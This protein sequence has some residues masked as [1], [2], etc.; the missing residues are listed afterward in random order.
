MTKLNQNT[1]YKKGVAHNES[2]R[3]YVFELSN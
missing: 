1:I 3:V 2:K